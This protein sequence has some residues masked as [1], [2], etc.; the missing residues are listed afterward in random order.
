MSW[1]LFLDES[2]HDHKNCPYEVRGGIA[3]QARKLWPF[4]Q[5]LQQA[6]LAA[7]GARLHEYRKEVK[8]AKL[9]DKDR[10][11]WADQSDWM[12]D[13]ARRKH[14]RGFLTKGL[15]K[16]PPS[17]DEFTAYGQACIEMARSVFQALRTF[18][19]QLFA[20]VIPT[21]VRKPP[22]FEAEEYLRKDHVFLLERYFYFLEAQ[23]EHGLLV[24]DE[25]EKVAD[26]RFIRQM[27]RYFS[28]TQTG[29]YRTAWIVPVPMFVASDLSVPMQAAD[30]AIYCI[31]WGFRLPGMGM[32]LAV[33][34]EIAR[35][36]G[37][38]LSQLQYRGQGYRDGRTF[39]SYGVVF[40][41]NP[42]GDGR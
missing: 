3:L 8:G 13:E 27:E 5:Q 4:V 19:A 15:E 32:D 40:V 23:R 16:L 14:C 34:E 29:R 28:K 7:F 33:R 24:F 9:L 25:V 37:P 35:E 6:E 22:T 39:D 41:P 38:W 42:Y 2:G 36:F 10:F 1:L 26:R 12:P 20:S 21:T 11:K 18:D 31:N 17:R 30:L